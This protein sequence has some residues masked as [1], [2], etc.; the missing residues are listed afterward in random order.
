M[1]MGFMQSEAEEEELADIAGDLIVLMATEDEL[2]IHRQ[3]LETIDRIS[4]GACLWK[5]L[6]VASALH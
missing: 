1:D 3:T 5:R 6:E 2:Q 4:R